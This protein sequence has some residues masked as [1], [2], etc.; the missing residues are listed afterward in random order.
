[1][2]NTLKIFL[3]SIILFGILSSVQA[4]GQKYDS[5]NFTK[6][7][8]AMR[9]DDYESAIDYF[10]KELDENPKNGFASLYLADI[11]LKQEDY[12]SALTTVNDAI[13]NLPRK[14]KVYRAYA[15]R[16]RGDIYYVLEEHDKAIDDFT[17]AISLYG[18]DS[19]M[20]ERR[21]QIYYEQ[22]R[23]DLADQDYRKMIEIDEGDVMGYMYLGRNAN[24]REN[25]E[26][27]I[28]YFDKV[29][30]MAPEYSSGYSF[31]AESYRGL[32]DYAKA[33]NDAITALS[34]DRD[35]K[36]YWEL[37]FIAGKEF[38][39]VLSRLKVAFAK[40]PNQSFWPNA[41]GSICE[42]EEVYSDAIDWYNKAY[43]IDR[44]GD[45]A[46]RIASCYESVGDYAHA[47]Q[48]IDEAIEM[49][50]DDAENFSMK[51]SIESDLGDFEQAVR[52]ISTGISM[53]PDYFFYYHQ[54]GRYHNYIG[55]TDEAIEDWTTSISLNPDYAY[56]YM[57][58]GTAYLKTGQQ[59]KAKADF[60]KVIAIDT[61]TGENIA[62][63][64][65]HFYL[66][67]AE[68]AKNAMAA[69]L[70]SD[71]ENYYYDACCLY[72]LLGETDT[73]IDYL[74][75][76]FET[77]YV[78]FN[79]IKVDSDLDNI[80]N[81]DSFISLIDK[82]KT[83]YEERISGISGVAEDDYVEVSTEIPM[84][85]EGGV[86]N[87][88]CTINGLPLHFI[89]DTGASDVS[90]SSLEASFM[91]KN[92]YLKH[93]DIIGSQNY[94]NADGEIS[95]GVVINLVSVEFGG[96]K[97]KNVKASVRKSQSAPLLLGQSAL[98]K[99]GK[100]E[101]DNSK[102]VIRVTHKVAKVTL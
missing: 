34:I 9:N 77:G 49:Q 15:Y 5:Y 71:P 1:M 41:A 33:V 8:E 24:A 13:K 4:F 39:I 28:S 23:Y 10:V 87:V 68:T 11:C 65:A 85:K 6:G 17:S 61:V 66:G 44:T 47:M 62:A 53:E 16:T 88:K 21:G 99:L 96:L 84:Y 54:R 36:A 80:R 63:V 98:S 32:E 64:Y 37:V 97:L 94:I 86:Y 75:K 20:Y 90:I 83:Q 91:L 31:R 51:S 78:G 48:Y 93:S 43:S 50:P 38:D 22:E 76:A 69:I 79:H 70:E 19:D 74:R 82:Y 25:Y 89:F 42:M 35:E 59:E 52:T 3:V 12:S 95:E 81:L 2:K 55:R 73:A 40:E 45:A 92:G 29:I 57:L 101:I 18:E 46:Y 60:E 30:N 100:I 102:N 7:L 58:R 14:S 56:P 26:E 67:D 72:S 27:A